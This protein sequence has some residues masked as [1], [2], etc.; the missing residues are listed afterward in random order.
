MHEAS[1]PDGGVAHHIGST[2]TTAFKETMYKE[3]THVY[4]YVI[5]YSIP[6]LY[7]TYYSYI[8]SIYSCS[9]DA[10]YICAVLSRGKK[11]GRTQLPSTKKKKDNWKLYMLRRDM[12]DSSNSNSSRSRPRCRV[13]FLS[14]SLYLFFLIYIYIGARIILFK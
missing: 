6:I 3:Y 12:A 14:F 1:D 11:E 13:F 8:Y 5:L 10:T 2:N 9:L 4:T 7:N